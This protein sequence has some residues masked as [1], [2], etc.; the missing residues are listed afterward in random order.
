MTGRTA[1]IAA[2]VPPA[3]LGLSFA[4]CWGHPLSALGPGVL[5]LGTLA[6]IPIAIA[7]LRSGPDRGLAIVAAI[8]TAIEVLFV[9]FVFA[10]AFLR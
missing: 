8:L 3:G 9:G 1:L 5:F 7:A 10:L 2:L 6:A 4:F